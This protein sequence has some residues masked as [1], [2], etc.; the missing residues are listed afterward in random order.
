MHDTEAMIDIM[1]M[2]QKHQV[3]LLYSVTLI[4]KWKQIKMADMA[5]SAGYHR[6]YISATLRG[7]Q[8]P[9]KEFRDHFRK[10]LGIDL[11]DYV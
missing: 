4:C 1:K 2:H 7:S 6:N 3:P 11:W 10:V 8:P 9:S 5:E